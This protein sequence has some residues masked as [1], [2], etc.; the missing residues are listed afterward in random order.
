[1][2]ALTD[3]VAAS[4]E[5]LFDQYKRLVN[6]VAW[7]FVRGYGGDFEEVQADSYCYFVE[8]IRGYD[9]T[10]GTQLSSHISFWIWSRLLDKWRAQTTRRNQIGPILHSD[11][12]SWLANE[13]I[14]KCSD[15]DLSEF[16]SSLTED[17]KTVVKLCLETPKE[18]AE[19]ADGKGG[20][21]RNYRSTVK[22]W[23]ESSGWTYKRIK[24]S[25]D[26]VRD[27]LE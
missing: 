4:I 26:E 6:D 1:M 22:Q 20:S 15:W 19:V 24:E 18:L 13:A 25:F 21:P 12:P 8:S 16:L 10:R 5:D 27:A 17:A 9:E 3:A 11:S 7:K 2:I 14:D 23:L